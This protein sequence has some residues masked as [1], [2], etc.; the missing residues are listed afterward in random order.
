[1]SADRMKIWGLDAA[2]NRDANGIVNSNG[3]ESVIE[4]EIFFFSLSSFSFYVRVF[5][6]VKSHHPRLKRPGC[7]CVV[8]ADFCFFF[9]QAAQNLDHFLLIGAD[10]VILFA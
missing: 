5:S 10:C 4:N 8:L 7:D 1:M 3:E 2:A 6:H 9:S